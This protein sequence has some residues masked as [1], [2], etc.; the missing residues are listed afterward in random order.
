MT[1]IGHIESYRK[2]TVKE[3][4]ELFSK[5]G[6][7]FLFR[8]KISVWS[9]ERW[10]IIV[11]YHYYYLAYDDYNISPH[12]AALESVFGSFNTPGNRAISEE[13]DPHVLN[14]VDF[15]VANEIKTVEEKSSIIKNPS[16]YRYYHSGKKIFEE[17]MW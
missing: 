8:K 13:T 16:I 10:D 6:V 17:R 2:F 12:R 11:A 15:M 5:I 14:V 7:Q 1:K 9:P 3:I 4:S